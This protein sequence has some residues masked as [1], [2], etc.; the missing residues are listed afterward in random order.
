MNEPIF[1]DDPEAM[2][3]QMVQRPRRRKNPYA[4]AGLVLSL[5]APSLVLLFCIQPKALYFGGILAVYI[6]V[7]SAPLA[8]F[9]SRLALRLRHERYNGA[10]LVMGVTGVILSVLQILF[11]VIMWMLISR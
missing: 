11:C 1:S 8:Y 7:V 2:P 9:V 5:I 6:S 3:E 10:G 4:I